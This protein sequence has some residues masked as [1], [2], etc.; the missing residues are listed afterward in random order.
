MTFVPKKKNEKK[1]QDLYSGYSVQQSQNEVQAWLHIWNFWSCGQHDESD[2]L[3]DDPH[4]PRVREA[5]PVRGYM[6]HVRRGAS[7][8]QRR[9]LQSQLV[10]GGRKLLL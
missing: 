3:S 7:S 6:D 9:E 1:C 2:W 4:K 8:L 10:S 5:G